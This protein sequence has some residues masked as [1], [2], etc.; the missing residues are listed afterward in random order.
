VTLTSYRCLP[1]G[2]CSR[3]RP[4]S[5]T[6]DAAPARPAGGPLAAVDAYGRPAGRPRWLATGS[7]YLALLEQQGRGVGVI[8][9][10][11]FDQPIGDPTNPRGFASHYTGWTL[12]LPARLVDHAAGRG[13][14]LMQVVGELGIGWQLAR[15]WTGTRTRERS[16]KRSGGAARRCPVCQLT[17]LGLALPARTVDPLAFELGARVA[18]VAALVP[19]FEPPAVAA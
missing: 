5:F 13:A 10:I 16:L 12:D 14:R 4:A 3:P 7:E 1:D 2:G 6:L 18:G 17:R 8:Y 9:L 11:H 19:P 15:I